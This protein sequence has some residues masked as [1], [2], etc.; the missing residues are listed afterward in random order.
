MASAGP[1]PADSEPGG[2][3]VCGDSVASFVDGRV[4]V[5]VC[6]TACSSPSAL[7]RHKRTAHHHHTCPYC[8]GG[9]THGKVVRHTAV[10]AEGTRR[11]RKC[12][13]CGEKMSGEALR[14]HMLS[15]HRHIYEE[16]QRVRAARNRRA[17]DYAR[18]G[19]VRTV[20]CDLCR[21]AF[22]S[23]SNMRRHRKTCWMPQPAV[24]PTCERPFH[25][26]RYFSH[27]VATKCAEDRPG[28]D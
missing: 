13:V 16:L 6:G 26:R 17:E 24:C 25:V 1:G 4:E 27:H 3:Y 21:M 19:C 20:R 11:K 8:L 7:A 9:F 18:R 28:D 14:T 23:V 5:A 2:A 12:V 22:S 15:A 10:C